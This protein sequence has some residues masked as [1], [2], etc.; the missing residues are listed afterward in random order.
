MM[1]ING[2]YQERNRQDGS[3]LDVV[4][5]VVTIAVSSFLAASL[6]ALAQK[7]DLLR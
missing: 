3:P 4:A 1:D 6:Q 5:L 7:G 2:T